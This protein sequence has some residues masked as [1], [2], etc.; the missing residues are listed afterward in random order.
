MRYLGWAVFYE[1]PSDAMYFDVLVPRILRDMILQEGEGLVEVAD[2]PSVRVGIKDRSSDAVAKE[3]C[4]FSKAFDVIF[5]HADT[6]GRGVE[7]GLG[8][9]AN[10]YCAAMHERCH[11]PPDRCVTIT[12][13]HE[14]EAWL[15]ADGFAVTDALGYRGDPVAVGLP[16][17][18]HE[19]ER[20]V[21]PKGTLRAA[22]EE[23]SGRR[24]RPNIETIFPA[25]AQRQR[26]DTLRQAL[27]FR[28]FE[29]GIRTCLRS[30]R[31]VA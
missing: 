25:I 31:L 23:I 6:G 2:S 5:I 13:R 8:Q 18:A 10:A 20:L 16:V 22:V 17:N 21:D 27:S 11:W 7:Q 29:D 15:L 9:R 19:A 30:L 24:K 3:A 14:T 4:A 12:P 28:H 1:G 26:L